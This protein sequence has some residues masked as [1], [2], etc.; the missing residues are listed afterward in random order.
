[1]WVLT[2]GYCCN[3]RRPPA[4]PPAG[5]APRRQPSSRE[6]EPAEDAEKVDIKVTDSEGQTLALIGYEQNLPLLAL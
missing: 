3:T 4:P 6:D 2:C 5:W 1:M